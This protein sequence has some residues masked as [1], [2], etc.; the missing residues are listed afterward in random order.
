MRF[1]F[2]LRDW[3]WLTLVVAILLAWSI[4]DRHRSAQLMSLDQQCRQLNVALQK[5]NVAL[6]NQKAQTDFYSRGR[7]IDQAQLNNLHDRFREMALGYQKIIMGLQHQRDPA[8]S[9]DGG[10][11]DALRPDGNPED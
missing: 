7:E 1:R 4:T 8:V 10:A 3:W 11:D 5:Q 2:T 6:Q 9:A